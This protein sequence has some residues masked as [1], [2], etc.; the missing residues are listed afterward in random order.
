MP[1]WRYASIVLYFA[2]SVVAFLA[3][4]SSTYGQPQL[5]VAILC[6]VVG[7][8]VCAFAHECGHA[9]AALARGWRVILFVVGPIGIQIP[10][11]D[12]AFVLKSHRDDQG[13]WIV[14]VPRT[15]EANTRAN[16][17]I[18]LVGG[19]AANFGIGSLALLIWAG[20]L[21]PFDGDGVSLVPISLGLGLQS[22]QAAVFS[23]LP[24][25]S[26]HKS[27]DGDQL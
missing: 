27:T 13:G 22:L 3:Y 14:A 6:M 9:L 2:V 12:F 20:Y 19:S 23:L 17:A 15:P 5:L 7:S 24:D 8:F 26:P 1:S 4:A 11:R 18:V 10:N 21:H 16:W 25:T